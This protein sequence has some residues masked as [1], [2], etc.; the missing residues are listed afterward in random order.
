VE[1][2][3][4]TGQVIGL[5]N[6]LI[7]ESKRKRRKMRNGFEVEYPDVR[8]FVASNARPVTTAIRQVCRK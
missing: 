8:M 3:E 6:S 2:L 4:F 5:D 1:R 7:V